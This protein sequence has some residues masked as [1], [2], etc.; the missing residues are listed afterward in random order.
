MIILKLTLVIAYCV[1]ALSFNSEA[2]R[3]IV[4]NLAWVCIYMEAVSYYFCTM[5]CKYTIYHDVA[6]CLFWA[7]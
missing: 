5:E 3:F 2:E 4:V 6:E 7:V 1:A